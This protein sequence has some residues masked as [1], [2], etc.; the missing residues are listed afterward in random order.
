MDEKAELK[1]LKASWHRDERMCTLHLARAFLAEWP[2]NPVAWIVLG[3]SLTSMHRYGDA[4][5]ALLKSIRCCPQEVNRGVRGQR[6]ITFG[7]IGTGTRDTAAARRSTSPIS[8]SS[9]L[10]RNR[11]VHT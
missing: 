11:V 8:T 3:S 10:H 2:D 1:R 7:G 5:K 9:A 4:R 6:Q